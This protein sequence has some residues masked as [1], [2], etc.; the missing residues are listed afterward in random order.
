MKE[1]E[2]E[3]GWRRHPIQP[4]C[5][6]PYLYNHAT[7]SCF[8][9][10]IRSEIY[11]ELPKTFSKCSQTCRGAIAV[12]SL[13]RVQHFSQFSSDDQLAE[14]ENAF[15]VSYKHEVCGRLQT[16]TRWLCEMLDRVN[17]Q[18]CPAYTEEQD[19]RVI[20][21]LVSKCKM[22]QQDAKQHNPSRV[23]V[24]TTSLGGGSSS[25]TPPPGG[26]TCSSTGSIPAW[27]SP[28]TSST[29]SG[30]TSGFKSSKVSRPQPDVNAMMEMIIYV[31][32]TL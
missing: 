29:R 17:F 21:Q 13:G 23:N 31:I 2:E 3:E 20:S 9:S 12:P 24:A 11:S 5:S 8:D 7:S 32:F 18:T 1:D 30:G 19:G 10:V 22:N 4:S 15:N 27:P 6:F 26:S 14:K 25:G 16:D 28:S